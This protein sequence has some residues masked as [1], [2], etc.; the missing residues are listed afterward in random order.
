MIP[1]IPNNLPMI[2]IIIVNYNGK[3][4]L[5]PCLRSLWKLNYPKEKFEVL[6]V[7]NVS[8]DGSVEFVR[9]NFPWVR[10]IEMDKNYGQ[11]PAINRS[12][13]YA[14]GDAIV[15]L[16]N[17]TVVDENWLSELVRV[18][19]FNESAGICG[20]KVIFMDAPNIIQY[21]G[22]YLH[23]LGGVLSP[24][25]AQENKL[26]QTAGPTGYVIGC[27]ML[28][29][30]D[31]FALIE[32]FDDDYSMYG[33]E[34]DLCWRTWL[35]GYSV[36]YNPDSIV[37]HIGGASRRDKL[38][39]GGEYEFERGYL[40][41]RLVSETNIYHGNKNAIF[42]ILKNLELKNIPSAL[43]FSFIYMLV[44]S[45]FLLKDKQGKFVLLLVKA[46]WWPI[47]NLRTIWKKRVKV[48]RKRKISDH[49]LFKR[50]L[51]LPIHR[52][53]KFILSSSRNR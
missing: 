18:A 6:L 43:L 29:K 2:S 52:L 47:V 26:H 51:M 49:V 23:T 53:L 32:G 1:Q 25:Y 12:F 9:E 37:Y 38:V 31:V 17:D 8:T 48:Q 11:M 20:S 16:D 45:L 35:Y 3:K 14:K 40:G 46:H 5:P 33:E 36:M 15:V 28:I 41:A 30:K 22:G 27:S 19:Y 10:T 44:Q 39:E 50:N 42:T 7:D 34:G 24:Y 13:Q 4:L 21:A